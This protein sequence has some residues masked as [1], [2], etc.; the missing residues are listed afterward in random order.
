METSTDAPVRPCVGFSCYKWQR[1]ASFG[2][3]AVSGL[4]GENEAL[5]P[6][7]SFVL[8]GVHRGPPD[9]EPLIG[10]GI[11]SAWNNHTSRPNVTSR[12][13]FWYLAK[14]SNWEFLSSGVKGVGGGARGRE[15]VSPLLS[16]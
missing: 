2:Q 13:V 12:S 3:A 14:L 9:N 4:W 11:N 7:A 15:D 5:A 16:L 1:C 10:A 6:T 8:S